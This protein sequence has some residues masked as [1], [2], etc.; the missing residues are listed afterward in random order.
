M[1]VTALCIRLLMTVLLLLVA[2]V[3]CSYSKNVDVGFPQVVPNRQ[4][5]FEYEPVTVTC[6]GLEG[7]TGWRV[8]R[9][10]GG[11]VKTCAASWSAST[12]PCKIKN[13]IVAVDSGEYWCEMGEA[14]KSNTVNITVTGGSVILESPAFPVM[15][16]DEVTLHCRNKQMSSNLTAAFFKDGHL[17]ENSSMGNLTLNSVS[18]SDE[19][20]YTCSIPEDGQPSA[21]WLIVREHTIFFREADEEPHRGLQLPLLL[22]TAVSVFLVALLLV[23]ILQCGK[24]QTI[25][26][27]TPT[28]PFCFQSFTS[29]QSVTT[30][31]V[32]KT[33]QE[34]RL[35]RAETPD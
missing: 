27:D 14:K 19:G 10:I 8:M 12:G 9:R 26:T 34:E 31:T 17:M 23:G 21:S 35:L 25:T 16:G 24:H 11:A 5:F 2:H 1:E 32:V 15:V 20:L 4:Q 13:A 29:I 28:S 6:E 22:C 33:Q 18:K 3:E 30:Y 7:L